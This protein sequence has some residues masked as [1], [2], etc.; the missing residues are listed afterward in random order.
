MLKIV[1]DSAAN[2]TTE[3]A[4]K[5]GVEILPLSIIFGDEIYRDGVDITTEE[6]YEKLVNGNVHPHTSQI[7]ISD[8]EEVFMRA[9]ENNDNL[10]LI[11]LSSALSGTVSCARIAKEN[12]GYDGVYI[13][14]SLGATVMEK[15]LVYAALK[16]ADKRAEEVAAILDDVRSRMVLYAAVDTL[17]YLY[18]GGRMKKSAA[19][20]GKLFNIKPL[21]TVSDKG[22]VELC[23]KA[24]GGKAAIKH[25]M[26]KTAEAV[27]DT[28][29]PVCYV[30][31]ADKAKAENLSAVLDV[32]D[33]CAKEFSNLCAV[34]GVHIGPGACGVCY[35]AHR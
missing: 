28:E 22:T 20:L 25:I 24:I 9:K 12:V 32:T 29:F 21:I 30:Y 8:F 11:L 35:I 2:L 7:N 16:N 13:Y 31:S 10:F 4:K 17:D 23:G 18:K 5:L 33:G 26:K 15:L 1:T 6:F 14:D 27:P 34:I 19:M 3:E